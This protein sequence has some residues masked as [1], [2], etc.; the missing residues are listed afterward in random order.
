MHI[1]ILLFILVSIG[2]FGMANQSQTVK[3][4]Q[5]AKSKPVEK[6]PKVK[7]GNVLQPE[8]TITENK[9]K[10]IKEYY[11]DGKLRAIKVVPKNGF[12]PYYLIDKEGNGKF[13]QLGPDMGPEVQVPQWILFEW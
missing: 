12:P 6:P 2:L 7:P 11:I 8:I 13:V 9:D 1:R 3:A 10:V 5:A 4:E